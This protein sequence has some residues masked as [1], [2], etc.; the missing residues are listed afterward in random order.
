MNLSQGRDRRYGKPCD[1]VRESA[2]WPVH[3][4]A[5]EQVQVQVINGLPRLR[6][7]VHDQAVAV[8]IDLALVGDPVRHLEE[9][10]EH[11]GVLRLQVVNGRDVLLR[12]DEDMRRSDGADI[13]EGDDLVV[14]KYFFRGDLSREDL[15]EQ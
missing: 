10:K 6:P 4:A 9:V 15:A 7:L 3:R 8:A 2:G 13:F 11:R 12:N 5:A 1:G 14:A